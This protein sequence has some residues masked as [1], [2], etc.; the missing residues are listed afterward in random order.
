MTD[1]DGDDKLIVRIGNALYGDRWQA[2]LAAAIGVHKDTVQDWR[3]G[4][5]A[6]RRGVIEDLRQIVAARRRTLDDIAAEI[7]DLLND[8]NPTETP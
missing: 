4:R 2:P 1:R 3:Q 5:T 6:P 8:R 7:D